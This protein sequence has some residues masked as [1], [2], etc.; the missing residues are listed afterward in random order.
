MKANKKDYSELIDKLN[1]LLATY[2]VVYFNIRSSHWMIKGENFFELHKVFETAYN[3][4]AVKIDAIAERILTLGGK[5]LLT[6]SDMVGVSQVKEN[7]LNGDQSKCVQAM[8]NDFKSLSVIENE[9]V[10][11]ANDAQDVVTADLITKYLG[12]QQKTGWMLSQFLDKR[13]TVTQLNVK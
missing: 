6:P 5:P 3:D 9:I 13:S 1:I 4:S 7:G 10:Q 8:L 11:L 2:Q 12:E